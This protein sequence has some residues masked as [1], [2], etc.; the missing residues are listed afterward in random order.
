MYMIHLKGKYEIIPK[1]QKIQKKKKKKKRS[2]F[3]S[4]NQIVEQT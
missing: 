1:V 3:C 4:L 2:D